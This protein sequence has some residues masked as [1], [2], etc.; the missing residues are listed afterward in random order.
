M[1]QQALDPFTLIVFL[2]EKHLIFFLKIFA[3]LIYLIDWIILLIEYLYQLIVM[4]YLLLL[5][6]IEII[7]DF[8]VRLIV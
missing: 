4:V 1:I 5:I 6:V 8:E 7:N 3:L 2:L